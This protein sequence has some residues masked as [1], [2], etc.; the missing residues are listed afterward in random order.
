MKPL[1]P[2]QAGSP[3]MVSGPTGSGKTYWIHKLLTNNMFTQPVSSVLY[4]LW[5]FSRL[6]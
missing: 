1:V 2:F 6:L 3:M 4:C 5:S